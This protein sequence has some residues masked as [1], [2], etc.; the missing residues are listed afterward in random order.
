MADESY[1]MWFWVYSRA[2]LEHQMKILYVRNVSD[3]RLKKIVV[4]GVA[5]PFT[6]ELK[7]M[8][9]SKFSDS[10]LVAKGDKRIMQIIQ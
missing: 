7:S 1:Y 3:L 10:I 5:K 4:N 8:K 6:C 2:Q 9:D